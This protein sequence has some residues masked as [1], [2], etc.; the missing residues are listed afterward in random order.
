MAEDLT[1]AMSEAAEGVK[2]AVKS[3]LSNPL[4]GSFALTW[5]LVN[6]RIVMVLLSGQTIQEKFDYLDKVVE[7][8][9]NEW[10]LHTFWIPLIAA[11]LYVFFWPIV[12]MGLERFNLWVGRKSVAR[13]LAS[14]AVEV[15]PVLE[16]ASLR[17]S[18]EMHVNAISSLKGEV[19]KLRAQAAGYVAVASAFRNAGVDESLKRYLNCQQFTL[20]MTDSV[21]SVDLATFSFSVEGSVVAT[22]SSY[23]GL[24]LSNYSRW[25]IDGKD[26]HLSNIDGDKK[27][28][29]A[30]NPSNG[31]FVLSFNEVDYYLKG[32]VFNPS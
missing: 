14:K 21:P 16:A 8:S 6:H 5:A 28:S 11:L 26:L 9:S 29:L 27:L 19:Y 2:D 7:G 30:F 15:M 17:S 13:Q 12:G 32:C 24:P 22:L 4:L 10:H 25:W 18:L 31:C 23:T 20:S 3:R 1:S